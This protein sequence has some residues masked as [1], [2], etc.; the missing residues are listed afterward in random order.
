MAVA[1]DDGG[2]AEGGT[3]VFR[4]DR[5]DAWV[6]ATG[7][8]SCCGYDVEGA[9]ARTVGAVTLRFEGAKGFE[10]SQVITNATVYTSQVTS[11]AVLYVTTSDA[12]LSLSYYF[13]KQ[14]TR[15]AVRLRLASVCLF[16]LASVCLFVLALV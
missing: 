10:A 4:L 12:T 8:I 13:R 3:L 15:S 16:V 5:N 9:G 11:W 2:V 7:D 1:I 14:H 6:P